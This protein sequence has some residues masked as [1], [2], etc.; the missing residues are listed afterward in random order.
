MAEEILNNENI[1]VPPCK[2]IKKTIIQQ[3]RVDNKY[4]LAKKTY[5]EWSETFYF[6]NLAELHI[7]TT[8]MFNDE[9]EEIDKD[10]HFY[11]G[12][13][14]GISYPQNEVH[15]KLLNSN[16]DKAKS[17]KIFKGS[18]I[19][20]GI[21]EKEMS[22]ICCPACASEIKPSQFKIQTCPYCEQKLDWSYIETVI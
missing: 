5:L 6:E 22:F 21:K 13:C 18:F 10:I 8:A 7:A 16:S 11:S 14:K 20:D 3:E 12:I 17:P 4:M 9:K 2:P 19:A 15:L 1:I